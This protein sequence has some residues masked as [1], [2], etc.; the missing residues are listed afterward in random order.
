MS[1]HLVQEPEL[2]YG[3]ISPALKAHPEEDVQMANEG[4]GGGGVAMMVMVLALIAIVGIFAYFM[5]SN[6]PQ[7]SVIEVPKPQVAM[8]TPAPAPAQ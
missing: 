6:K 2:G 7:S 4:N 5:A 8:P 1:I 3:V